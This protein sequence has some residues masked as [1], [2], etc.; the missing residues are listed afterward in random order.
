MYYVVYS[1][2][3]IHESRIGQAARIWT[4]ATIFMFLGMSGVL[5]LNCARVEVTFIHA[6]LYPDISDVLTSQLAK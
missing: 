5:V 2:G 4:P 3:N 6:Y 1:E